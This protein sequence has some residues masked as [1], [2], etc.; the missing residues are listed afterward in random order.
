MGHLRTKAGGLRASLRPPNPPASR[1]RTPEVPDLLEVT[2]FM[3]AQPG[4]EQRSSRPGTPRQVTKTLLY[5]FQ[6]ERKKFRFFHRDKVM[7]IICKKSG[8]FQKA[9]FKS[10]PLGC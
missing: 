3:A 7:W 10:H 8:K 4:Q 1:Q 9:V 6:T 2:K 5:I